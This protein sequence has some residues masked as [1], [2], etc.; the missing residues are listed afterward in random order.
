MKLNSIWTYCYI[1]FLKIICIIMY[2][3]LG[4][5]DQPEVL[6]SSNLTSQGISRQQLI[7][8]LVLINIMNLMLVGLA[9]IIRQKIN[10]L[11]FCLQS[12]PDLWRQNFW[13]S[14]RNLLL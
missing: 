14:L 3:L 13:I 9:P 1:L 7:N 12:L 6:L 11:S 2:V 8:R 5:G 4:E 10:H